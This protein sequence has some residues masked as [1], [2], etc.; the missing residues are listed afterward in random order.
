MPCAEAIVRRLILTFGGW[1]NETYWTV[2]VS[3]TICHFVLA[4]GDVVV[5]YTATACPPTVFICTGVLDSIGVVGADDAVATIDFLVES[6]VR[7]C[8]TLEFLEPLL[9]LS[10]VDCW[11]LFPVCGPG[12]GRQVDC[13]S[14]S[15]Q[16]RIKGKGTTGLR[17]G[18][19]AAPGSLAGWESRF[20]TW[21]TT[22]NALSKGDEGTPRLEWFW[23]LQVVE[24]FDL[25]VGMGG[26]LEMGGVDPGG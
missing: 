2:I 21:T 8:V 10:R 13:K 24:T 14:K 19:Q 20:W 4:G 3:V 1:E 23:R 25:Q 18:R 22:T 15:G 26:A 11:G 16:E 12:G 7:D 5:S 6:D 17:N 9:D